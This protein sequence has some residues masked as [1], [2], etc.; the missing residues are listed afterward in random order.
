M[1]KYFYRVQNFQNFHMVI[2]CD[3]MT[4]IDVSLHKLVLTF[5]RQQTGGHETTRRGDRPADQRMRQSKR[6]LGQRLSHFY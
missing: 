6:M 5:I 1:A 2:S 3:V 4:A